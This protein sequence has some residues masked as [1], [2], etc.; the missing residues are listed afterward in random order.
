MF[1]FLKGVENKYVVINALALFVSALFTLSNIVLRDLLGEKKVISE[2]KIKN[3][4]PISRLL[5]YGVPL[6]CH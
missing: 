6:R 5:S 4:P 1:S 3:P 2:G